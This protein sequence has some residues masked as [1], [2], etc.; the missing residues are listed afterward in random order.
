MWMSYYFLCQKPVPLI[1]QIPIFKNIFIYPNRFYVFLKC[2]ILRNLFS[3][4][5]KN[6]FSSLPIIHKGKLL[7][8]ILRYITNGSQKKN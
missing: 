8:K 3:I 1:L 7:S 2:G 4:P 6:V 5:K